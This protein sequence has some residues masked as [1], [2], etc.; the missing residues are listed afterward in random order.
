M[1]LAAPDW[2]T[3]REKIQEFLYQIPDEV[4]SKDP[5]FVRWTGMTHKTLQD[6]WDGG[7]ILTSCN[8]FAGKIATEIGVPKKS[9]LAKGALDISQADKEVP[10]CWQDAN[11]ADACLNN[12]TPQ[13]GDFYS[14]WAKVK[15]KVKGKTTEFIQKFAHVGIVYSFEDDGTWW[16]VQGGQG[17]PSSKMDFI[18]WKNAKFDRTKINGWV[19]IA[20]YLMPD[21]PERSHTPHEYQAR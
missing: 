3:L 6:N 11:S 8:A 18:R 13:A 19:N 14:S 21:G 5:A 10:G 16:L 4:S 2:A 12:I 7:G 1:G 17:G 9:V 20:K 15:V